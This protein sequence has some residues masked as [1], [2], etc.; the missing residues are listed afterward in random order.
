MSKNNPAGAKS[1]SFILLCFLAISGLFLFGC[2]GNQPSSDNQTDQYDDEYYDDGYYDDENFSYDYSSQVYFYAP[3]MQEGLVGTP[4]NESL[5]D[6]APSNPNDLCGAFEDADNPWGGSYPYHFVL[7]SGVGFLPLGLTLNLNGLI[8]G[9]PTS[10]GTSEFEVCAVD[11]GGNQDCD[12]VAITVKEPLKINIHFTGSG[13]GS[14]WVFG[15]SDDPIKCYSDCVVNVTEE[16]ASVDVIFAPGT[17]S[18]FGGWSGDCSYY[19]CSLFMTDESKDITAEFDRFEFTASATC[20]RTGDYSYDNLVTVTG[21]ATGPDGAR[22]AI[23]DTKGYNGF[24]YLAD[25]CGSWSE[26][27]VGCENKGEAG[28]TAW[29]SS[30]RMGSPTYS[31]PF[32]WTPIYSLSVSYG[33]FGDTGQVLGNA[34]SVPVVVRCP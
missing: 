27:S 25:D 21:T 33:Q 19:S 7:G 24:I 28:S 3:Y 13:T 18:A 6:P 31:N 8:T 5:C 12:T 9:T 15:V 2:T 14:V 30:F 20:T 29:S 23:D 34:I 17:D 32:T 26:G 11:L 16:Y 4:Y 1:M 10:A 22:I